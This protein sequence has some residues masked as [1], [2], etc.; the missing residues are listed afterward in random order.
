MSH[1]AIYPNQSILSN[2]LRLL[3]VGKNRVL[4]ARDLQQGNVAGWRGILSVLVPESNT[5]FLSDH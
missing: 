5:S 4:A 1:S 2:N 3:E